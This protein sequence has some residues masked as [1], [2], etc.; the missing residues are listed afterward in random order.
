MK[1]NILG[2]IAAVILLVLFMV[3]I[4][5]KLIVFVTE[6][7]YLHI[8]AALSKDIMRKLKIC[9]VRQE[10]GGTITAHIYRR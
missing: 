1:I 10:G 7:I 6:K 9:I 4:I 8:R 5:R 3:I 2:I